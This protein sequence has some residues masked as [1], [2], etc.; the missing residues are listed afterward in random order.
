MQQALTQAGPSR[1]S[2]AAGNPETSPTIF[3]AQQFHDWFANLTV[4]TEH[5]QDSLYRDHHAEISG[6]REA[7]DA[8]VE[9][10]MESEQLVREMMGNLAYVEERSESL[11]GACEN[12]LEE[13]VSCYRS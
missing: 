8:L 11:R 1:P 12:L 5:E 2:S 9:S 4:S 7:C 10:L 3:T 6:Y 13:Q